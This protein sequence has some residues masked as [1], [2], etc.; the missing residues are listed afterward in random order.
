MSFFRFLYERLETCAETKGKFQ[1]GV[2]LPIPCGANPYLEVGL[3]D[4]KGKIV[5]MLDPA[6]S[7]S[8][9][10]FYRGTRREDVLLQKNG[11]R[12]QRLLVE[13][14]CTDLDAALDAIQG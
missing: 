5:V 4:A 2:R 1:M 14:V 6:S 12:V 13:D 10:E 7:L 11:Y 3:L 8:D 9:I